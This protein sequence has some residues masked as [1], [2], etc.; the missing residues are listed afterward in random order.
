MK[1]ESKKITDVIPYESNPRIIP[2]QA[3]ESIASSIKKFGW[4]QPIIID[5][6]NVIIAGHTRLKAAQRLG[7]S[8][9]P[10][11]IA[12]DLTDEDVKKFRILDNKLGEL[13]SWDED[14]L[15]SELLQL[16][17]AEFNSLFL[18]QDEDMSELSKYDFSVDNLENESDERGL[19][20]PIIQYT[21]IFDNE[22]QQTSWVEFLKKLRNEYPSEDSIASKIVRY[23]KE[24]ENGE[25]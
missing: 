25:I 4:Q 16:D 10:V 14:V 13:S 21:I 11:H 18:I 2:E 9:V 24:K 8:E 23:L 6:Q 3:I 1:I 22:I 15:E 19:G 12:H 17:M 7:L 5:K 20:N